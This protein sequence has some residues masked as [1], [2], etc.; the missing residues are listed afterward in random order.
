MNITIDELTFGD[1]SLV[2]AH[3]AHHLIRVVS[4][5]HR[6]LS[7]IEQK[8]AK[9]CSARRYTTMF[10][11]VRNILFVL[12][13][14]CWISIAVSLTYLYPPFSV[15]RASNPRCLRFRKSLRQALLLYQ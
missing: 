2:G 6:Q 4:G 10:P 8:L 14:I 12:I 15:Q 5:H 7:S 11:Y 1:E 3:T 13:W 9:I